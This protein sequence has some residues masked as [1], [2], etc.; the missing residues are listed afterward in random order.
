VQEFSFLQTGSPDNI[1]A[2]GREA[3]LAYIDKIKSLSD[4]AP[5]AV[6]E[7]RAAPAISV[8]HDI[9]IQGL[10]DQVSSQLRR[11]FLRW[12]GKPL[13]P[14]EVE[15]AMETMMTSPDIASVEYF[16]ERDDD[17]KVT[18][19]LN[20][21]M[22]PELE[23]GLS[24][25]TTNLHPYRW[26]YLKGAARGVLSDLDS[27][28]GVV[29][30]GDQWGI[31]VSYLTAP[32]PLSSW[33]IKLTA[34]RWNIAT[35]EGSS[36]NWDR[37]SLGGRYLFRVGDVRMGAGVAYE[38]VKGNGGSSNSFGPTFFAAYDSLDIPADPTSGQ[39]WRFN[40]WWP[41]LDD[42]LYRVTFF[43]PLTIGNTWRTYL[44]LGY[45]EGNMSAPGHAAYLGAAEELY[46]IAARP[47]EAE[48]MAWA[49]IAFRRIISRSIWG[50]VAAEFFGGYGYAMDKNYNK[51]AAPWEIGVAINV[52]N[53]L[54]NVKLAAMYGSEGFNLGFF[55][56]IPIWDH[57]P[58]P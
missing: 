16:L 36:H 58:L 11:T 31:D 38:H 56:G 33:E 17:G 53:N 5:H 40:A 6:L 42:I 49:N 54:I 46:S 12:A 8:V 25:Y 7:R 41:D 1:I 15:N 32:E 14:D 28:R 34:Q 39:A 3:A 51:I 20:V 26:L 27:I 10:P 24:G 55:M 57:Y 19:V 4:S 52:P 30:V 23:I 44:R 50:I 29:R 48:R 2:R 45:A 37:Y 21:R 13:D 9:R 18:L 22:R 43:R 47:I 35:S